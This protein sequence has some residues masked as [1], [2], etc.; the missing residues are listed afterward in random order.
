MLYRANVNSKEMLTATLLCVFL[1]EGRGAQRALSPAG[2]WQ[3]KGDETG[4]KGKHVDFA[5][6]SCK[7]TRCMLCINHKD[8][9]EAGRMSRGRP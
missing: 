1:G 2:W 6:F 7:Y 8:R 4:N 5:G 3:G 9:T